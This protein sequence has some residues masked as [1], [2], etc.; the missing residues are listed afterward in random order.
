V[1]THTQD[2]LNLHEKSVEQSEVA[3][4]DAADGGHGL[5]VRKVSTVE[6]Q[7]K[8]APVARQHKRELIALKRTGVMRETDTAIELRITRHPFLD[9]RHTN[10]HQANS[11]PIKHVTQIFDG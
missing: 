8:F 1:D 10:E 11:R 5:R 6:R 7:A 3:V 2:T 4:G 9:A